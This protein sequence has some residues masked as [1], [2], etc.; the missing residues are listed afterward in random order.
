[1]Q[2]TADLTRKETSVQLP[3]FI[4]IRTVINTMIR[5]VYPFL[6]FFSRGLGVDLAAL[7]YALSLRSLAGLVGPLIAS[8]ADS[9][10]RKTGML[11]GGFLFTLG[12][13]LVA[14]WPIYPVFVLT[15]VL[16]ILGNFIFIPSMQAYLGDRISYQRRGRALALVEIGWSLSFIVGVPAAGYLIAQFGWRSPFPLMTLLGLAALLVLAWMLPKDGAIPADNRPNMWRN[17]RIV[18]SHKPALAG[19][20]FALLISIGNEVINLV[21]G[22][23]LED[24]F[25]LKITALGVVAAIIGFAEL[26]GEALISGLVDRLGKHRSVTGGLIFNCLVVTGMAWFGKVQTGAL[27]GLFLFYL[28]FEFTLVGSIPIMTEILPGARAT[29]MAIYIAGM[30]LGRA[31]GASLALP[32]YHWGQSM[33]FLPVLLVSA[34]A[35]VGF[36]LLALLFL[37]R[38]HKATQ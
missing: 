36:N 37:I 4:I 11:L 17:F 29:M 8:V 6:S 23:W 38:I 9:R 5:M 28:T 19:V 18:L 25:G 32:L 30:S 13:G 31:A 21:F 12:V 3:M 7:S 35:T 22:V 34:L 15:L 1:M 20:A 10:G 26:G 24:S 33:T 14:I 16:T 2:V 27:A